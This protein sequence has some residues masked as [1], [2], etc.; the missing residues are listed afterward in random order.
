MQSMS[1]IGKRVLQEY[2]FP[3]AFLWRL[4]R[5][6]DCALTF[7]DGPHVEYTPQVLDLLGQCGVKATFFVVG[8]AAAKAPQ[9]TRRIVAEGHGIASHT[10]SHRDMPTLNRAE[11]WEELTSCRKLIADLTGVD[12]TLVRPPRGRVDMAALVRMKRW[13]YRLIH[14]SKTYS[15]YLHDGRESLL[16]R[17]RTGGLDACDIAL[18]HD[19]NG[20]TVEALA[21][22]LPEWRSRGRSFVRLQ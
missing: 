12:T 5:G 7:D 6:S 11:L 13:G 14:W 3:D 4:R 20:H 19:N 10:F 18:F 1:E 17:I 2:L 22:M 16:R 9:L 21:E 15:D 8:Q